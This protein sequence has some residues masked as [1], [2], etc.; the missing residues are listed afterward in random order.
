MSRTMA[1]HVRCKSLYISLLSSAKQQREMTKLCVFWRN[2]TTAANFSYFYLELNA[3]ITYL[4]WASFETDRN[5]SRQLQN[6][7]VKYKFIFF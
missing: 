7:K 5:K 3:G 2:R 4:I 1:V 6:A